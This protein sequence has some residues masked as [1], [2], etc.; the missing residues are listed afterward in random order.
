MSANRGSPARRE[1]R[2]TEV[3]KPFLFSGIFGTTFGPPVVRHFPAPIQGQYTWKT[4]NPFPVIF[5][6]LKDFLFFRKSNSAHFVTTEDP[7]NTVQSEETAFEQCPAYRSALLPK[8]G[9]I[10]S[11]IC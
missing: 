11:M 9:Q 6:D 4:S 1:E 3:R 7:V 10:C 2:E 8:T 5:S